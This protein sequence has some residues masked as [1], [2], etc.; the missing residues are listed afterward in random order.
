MDFGKAEIVRLGLMRRLRLLALRTASAILA[1][2]VFG[3]C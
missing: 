2:V 1:I 3:G